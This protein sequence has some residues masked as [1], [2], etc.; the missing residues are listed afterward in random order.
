L[1]VAY[2]SLALFLH[3][4]T[5]EM[6]GTQFLRRGAPLAALSL[7]L[8]LGVGIAPARSNLTFAQ[9]FADGQM[10]TISM[11]ASTVPS[12]GDVNPY[13]VAVVP[14]T[15][16]SL[17]QGDILVSNFNNASNLQG[18]G[19]TIVQISPSGSMQTFAQIDPHHLPSQCTGGIGLTT[20][21]AVTRNGWVFVGSLPTTDCTPKTARAGC[22]V[23]LDNIG[24]VV[25]TFFGSLING[26]WD[27]TA[28]DGG[29]HI[30]LFV[31]NVLNGTLAGHGHVVNAGTV[32]RLDVEAPVGLRPR[33]MSINVIGSGFSERTD[34]SALVIGPTGVAL[35]ADGSVLYVAD[36]LNNRIA[37]ISNPMAR[38]T[39][40][41]VGQTLTSGGSLNDPLGLAVASNGDILTVNGDDG[42]LVRTNANGRQI[43]TRM[44]DSSGSPPGAGAL[45]GLA[46]VPNQGIYFVDDATNTLD[47]LH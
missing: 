23:V 43:A 19:T 11:I 9:A 3:G 40:D 6:I 45:F 38:R 25:E 30:K 10:R 33:V 1:W 8:A 16:G 13:G 21:L 42:L 20:A 31:T 17:V 37:A 39:S 14:A 5:I 34:P 28:M 18:T 26:P 46:A 44:L 12:N 41:G 36:S 24:R 27:M 2:R 47:L 15:M 4:S 32:I 22:I 35:N 7:I 29:S